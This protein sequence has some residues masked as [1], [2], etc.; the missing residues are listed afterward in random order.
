MSTSNFVHVYFFFL[1][2]LSDAS[3]SLWA[4]SIVSGGSKVLSEHSSTTFLGCQQF[5]NEFLEGSDKEEM[6]HGFRTFGWSSLITAISITIQYI[7]SSQNF[8]NPF[9]SLI[10]TVPHFY[11][12][13]SASYMS[14]FATYFY[15]HYLHNVINRRGQS[16]G[17]AIG[18]GV[19]SFELY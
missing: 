9:C 19:C 11:A 1:L 7:S 5:I 8:L 18:N 16:V 14:Y 13:N 4:G 12:T 6:Q 15:L 10:Q 3:R 2:L 17:G